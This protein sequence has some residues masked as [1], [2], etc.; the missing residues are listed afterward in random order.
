MW[1]ADAP[2]IS[3]SIPVSKS[4]VAPLQPESGQKTDSISQDDSN[5]TNSL[6]KQARATEFR[7]ERM[8]KFRK[9]N[10]RRR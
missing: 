10:W 7:P 9:Q 6:A 2:D 1:H 5:N 3:E 8:F 4:P